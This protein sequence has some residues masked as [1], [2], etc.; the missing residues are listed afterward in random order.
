MQ[1][2]PLATIN[3]FPVLHHGHNATRRQRRSPPHSQYAPWTTAGGAASG[4][5]RPTNKLALQ[6]ALSLAWQFRLYLFLEKDVNSY[7]EARW[8]EHRC[9]ARLSALIRDTL[10]GFSSCILCERCSQDDARFVA[11][12]ATQD[13]ED[14]GGGG[15]V[16]QTIPVLAW[17][18]EG[19]RRRDD[20]GFREPHAPTLWLSLA[21]HMQVS[22]RPCSIPSIP[23]HTTTMEY[24]S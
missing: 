19:E 12:V 14:P 18:Q 24:T 10:P 16:K 6:G 5:F 13:T 8:R 1:C 7:R 15:D 20:H 11:Q 17:M 2:L 3:P 21:Q 4:P 22:G 9:E 23:L